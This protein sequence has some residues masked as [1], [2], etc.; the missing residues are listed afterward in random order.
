THFFETGLAW[1]EADEQAERAVD[2]LDALTEEDPSNRALGARRMQ[3]RCIHARLLLAGR[4]AGIEAGNFATAPSCLQVR[5]CVYLL[6]QF[7]EH[8]PVAWQENEAEALREQARNC[9][10]EP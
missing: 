5:D 4:A 2:L 6:D 3:A 10:T 7:S 8:A 9:A 1:P